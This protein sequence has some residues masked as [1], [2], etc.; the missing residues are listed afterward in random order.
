MVNTILYVDGRKLLYP[1]TTE[2]EFFKLRNSKENLAN[3]AKARLGDETAK[4][5]LIEFNYSLCTKKYAPL[6][7]ATTLGNTFGMDF[8][9]KAPKGLMGEEAKQWYAD[10]VVRT[11]KIVDEHKDEIGAVMWEKSP[12][13]KGFHLVCK[14]VE[15]L[16]QEENLARVGIILGIP[17]DKKA[18]D[19]TRVFFSSSALEEDIEIYDEE[20]L[21][22]N[23]PC[24]EPKLGCEV[25]PITAGGELVAHMLEFD[26]EMLYG[27]PIA[28]AEGELAVNGVSAKKVMDIYIRRNY[29]NGI[30][31]GCRNNETFRMSSMAATAGFD[32]LTALDVI[33]NLFGNTEEGIREWKQTVANG[34]NYGRGKELAYSL[35]EIV[36]ELK[37]S[38]VMEKIGGTATC[39]PEMSDNS[40]NVLKWAVSKVQPRLYPAVCNAVLAALGAHLHGVQVRNYTGELHE[41]A[42]LV[43]TICPQS[44]G[45]SQVEK[46]MMAAL[47][48]IIERDKENFAKEY[49]WKLRK[50]QGHQEPEPEVLVQY[51]PADLTTAAL[52]KRLAAAQNMGGFTLFMYCC[53]LESLKNIADKRTSAALGLLIRNA[54]D[55]ALGGQDRVTADAVMCHQ[56]KTN[57]NWVCSTTSRGAFTELTEKMIADGTVSRLDIGTI[58][59]MEEG[60]SVKVGTYDEAYTEGFKVYQDRLN[61]AHGLIECPEATD[62]AKELAEKYECIA[63][64]CGSEAARVFARRTLLISL[65]KAIILYI[66]N[67]NQW[68]EE[69]ADF[70]KWSMAYGV[71]NK[72][73]FFGKAMEKVLQKEKDF[74][75]K[76]KNT[77]SEFSKYPKKFTKAEFLAMGG[78]ESTLRGWKHKKKVVFDEVEGVYIKQ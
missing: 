22:S 77:G 15:G 72:M 69:I 32:E 50:R 13:G 19:P 74:A 24:P 6:K 45:K 35:K 11:K 4:K 55:R 54:F 39:P 64:E 23:V 33:P 26:D 25:E 28:A 52:N 37:G 76:E 30:E 68:C 63:S 47:S 21:F 8:D 53:E 66:C 57:I 9:F 20:A 31:V 2:Q 78:N 75:P 58:T 40:P 7:G 5:R 34:I 29:P 65:Y 17:Y 27:T 41:P 67:G 14:R 12:S 3:L 36:D 60:E 62:L 71:W 51:L 59:Q 18:K 56:V 44:N 10:E 1:I 73:F 42:L 38:T 16:T 48:D 49:A 43:L 61:K 70:F 46:P